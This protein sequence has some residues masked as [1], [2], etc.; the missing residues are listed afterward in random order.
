M[1]P[2]TFTFT[3]V[4]HCGPNIIEYKSRRGLVI[5]RTGQEGGSYLS[6][7]IIGYLTTVGGG[8]GELIVQ[9]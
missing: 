8:G 5:V 6:L 4:F 7:N 2:H 9:L 3:Y 1:K